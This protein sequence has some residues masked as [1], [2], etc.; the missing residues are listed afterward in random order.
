MAKRALQ[1]RGAGRFRKKL[2]RNATLKD[3]RDIVQLN[4]VEMNAKAVRNVPVLTGFLKRSITIT[5]FNS[6]LS[7]KSQ[8]TAEYAAHVEKGTR[9]MSGRFYMQRA[10]DSQ[11]RSFK[12]D[13][14]RLVK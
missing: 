7:G 11:K 12:R 10:Y 4:V 6:A 1:I 14:K 13:L 3:V 5:F 2:K 9:F 8:A